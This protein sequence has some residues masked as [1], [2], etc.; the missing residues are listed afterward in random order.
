MYKFKIMLFSALNFFLLH[1]Y[2]LFI[3][4]DVFRK[5]IRQ[6]G[7]IRGL[8]PAGVNIMA[9][10]ASATRTVRC[11]VSKRLSLHNPFILAIPSCRSNIKYSVV[12][13]TSMHEAL[14]GYVDDVR[15]HKNDTE[16]M[17]IY[18]NTFKQC[19]D[20]R[21]FFYRELQMDQFYPTDIP[22][23]RSQ[24][25]LVDT[26]TSLTN[27]LVKQT[28]IKSFTAPKS[29]LCIVIA[30]SAFG[31]GVDC[32]RVRTVISFGAP[33]DVEDYIQQTG[34]VGRDGLQSKAVLLWS[35]D[36]I[37]HSSDK[38]KDYCKT[39]DQCRRDF[40]F[41]DYDNYDEEN[42]P[43]REDCCDNCSKTNCNDNE[44]KLNSAII[45]EQGLKT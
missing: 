20:V 34:R 5:S 44:I 37:Q 18:C 21:D 2:F 9:L 1:Y 40:L 11:V 8:L 25:Q 39:T 6:I 24:Y 33:E 19:C 32:Q 41:S 35:A 30:T 22:I 38:L 4:G 16:R 7:E 15:L 42:K 27:L 31:M 28:I 10:S 36:S 14:I 12:K 45:D 3:G 43:K 26:Y 17:I 13:F 29:T 23:D